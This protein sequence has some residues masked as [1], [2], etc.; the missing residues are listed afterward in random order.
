PHGSVAGLVEWAVSLGVE[1]FGR[2]L[3]STSLNFDV[4]VFELFGTLASGGTLEVVRDV[5][6]LAERESWS[7]SLVSAVPS[8]FAAVL[9][10]DAHV[11]AGLV[12]LAGEAFPSGL[13][14]RIGQVMP[15]AGV[16]NL[17]GP[18]EATVYATG[19]FSGQDAQVDGPMVPIGRSVAG[20]GV[21]V[22]DAWLRPVPVGVWGEL[23]LAGGLARGYH[24]RAGLTSERFVAD[25]FHS[26]GRLYRTGDVV[27]RGAD[28]VLE[29]AG[30]GDDQVKVRGFRIELG[31]IESVLCG[32]GSVSRAVVVAREDRPGVKRLAAY[33]VTDGPDAD[34]D[35]GAVR[36]HVA[37]ALPEYMVPSAF[38]VLEELPLNANGKLDRK[39]LPAPEFTAD[40]GV[41]VAPRTDTER[42][43]ASVWG[44]VLG[45]ADVGVHDNFFDL[46]GDSI[47]SLQVVSRARRAGLAVSSR[48][49][50]Q[51]PTIAALATHARPVAED[52]GTRTR[53]VEAGTVSGTVA[54]T[55]VREW[56]FETHPVAPGHF[57]MAAS[58]ALPDG[59]DPDALRTAVAALTT[60]HDALRS[61]FAR[62]DDGT[63]TG[64]LTAGTDPDA[65][66]TLHELPD[67]DAGDN[68][69]DVVVRDAQAGLDLAAGPL[70][71][72]LVRTG[73]DGPVRVV[74][75]A[76]HLVMDGVSWRILLEDLATAYEQ[77]RAG[78]TP[79]LGPKGTSV[80][81][82]ADR[83]TA[84][85]REGG[86]DDQLDHWREAAAA[87]VRIPV[88]HP[89]GDNTVASERTVSVSL[90]AQETRALLF[91]VPGAYRTRP[92]DV[93]LAAL[94]RAVGP[95]ATG[96]TL[97]VDGHGDGAAG[98]AP[99]WAVNL[100]AHGRGELFDDVDLTRTVGWFTAI[101]PV[102]LPVPAD[103]DWAGTV[104]TVKELLRAVPDQGIGYGAL[105]Y[106]AGAT[107]LGST[108]DLAFN[109]L[110]Q[111]DEGTGGLHRS[112][113]L[114]PGGEHHPAEQRPHLVEVVGAVQDGVLTFTWSYSAN[115][116]DR[117]TVETLARRYADAL[118]SLIAHC[119]APGRP[120][121]CTPSDFPL[122]R[123]AQHEVD[124]LVARVGDARAV[125]DVLPLTPLQSGMLF[126]TLGAPGSPFYLEQFT[127]LME[128]VGD[129]ETVARAWQAV[130]D[131]S[132]A[133]RV[134]VVWEGVAEP[135][136]IVHR[137][138]TRPL[139]IVYADW[140]GRT[141]EERERLLADLLAA[142]RAGAIGLDAPLM[143][144]TL[145]R[146]AD[147]AVRVVW[148]FHHLLMDG[149]SAAAVL[150]DVA[151]LCAGELLPRREPFRDHLSRL[152][153][154]DEA[155]GHAFWSGRLAGFEE[156][157]PLPYDRSPQ[158]AHQACSGE[159]VTLGLAEGAA[160]AV[161]DFARRNRVTVGAVVQG[162]WALL[163]GQYAGRHDVVFGT[164]VSGR[165][166][167]LPGAESTVGLFIN[168]VPVRVV[169]EPDEPVGA[170]LR[171]I[172]DAQ[173]EARA[174]EQVPL[175]GIG[176]PGLPS[177]TPLFDSLVVVENYPVHAVAA[178]RGVTVS[179]LEAVESTNYPLTLTA[180]PA[181][182][183][184]LT[185]GFD[186]E[187]FDA[188]TV[189]LLAARYARVLEALAESGDGA[190]T[191]S[192][193]LLAADERVRVLGGE[194]SGTLDADAV[195]AISLP[196][197][198]ARL[199]AEDPDAV[200]VVGAGG[201]LTRRELD[202]RAER[203]AAAL[204]SRGAGPGARIGLLL[205]RSA[206]VV[207]AM[208][209]VLRTGAAYVPLHSGH[210]ADRMRAMLERSGAL[211]LLTDGVFTAPP[212]VPTLDLAEVLGTGAVPEP[213]VPG[214]A[215][216]AA[217]PVAPDADAYVMYT[218]GSTGEPK[219]VA[220]T[221][222]DIVALA[223]DRRWTRR[224]QQCV[225]F[226]SSHSF[227]AA[228][229]EVW[230]PLLNGGRVVVADGDLTADAVRR[231]VA[232]HG[233]TALFVTTALFGA[234]ADEDPACF[235][236]LGEVWT[237][238][239]AAS[240]PAMRRVREHCS[241]TRLVH[242]YGPTEATAF[243]VC[244]ALDTADLADGAAVPLGLPMDNTLAYVLD[245]ALR[246]VGTGQPGELY[247]GGPGLARGYDGRPG[248]TAERFVADPYGPAG[249]RLYRT[250]DLVRRL[251]DGRLAFLGRGDGQVKIRGFRIELA[252]IE[253]ALGR[254]AGVGRVSVQALAA[255]PDGS[256]KRLVAYLVPAAVQ[257]DAAGTAGDT[258]A[259]TASDPAG[260]DVPRVREQARA[261]LPSY[262]VP[263][264]F[265]VLDALPLNSS[266]KVDRRALPV[267][268]PETTLDH[269]PPRAGT[270]ERIAAVWGELL[271][272]VR[273]GRHD[274]FFALGGDS[275]TSLKAASRLRAALGAD[276][277][278]RTLFDHPT[279]ASLATACAAAADVRT[280]AALAPAPRGADPLPLSYAQERLWFLDAFTPGGNEYN[281]VT[282]LR[283]LG[284]LDT[285][286]LRAAVTAL[287]AR[288]EALR[289]TFGTADGRG[290][291]QR[292]H[293]T[294]AVPV[295][296]LYAADLEEH[297]RAL[298][299]EATAPFDLSTGPLLRVLLVEGPAPDTSTLMLT[300]HHIVT[301]GW[302]MGVVTRELS[303]L[304]AAAADGSAADAELP[305]LPLQ[306]PD[307]AVW[308]RER[309]TDA[310]LA[311]HIDHWRTRL[312][313]LEPLELP[314]DRPRPAVRTG[315]GALH[316]FRVPERLA[317]AL[318]DAARA[319]GAT[320]SMALTAVTQLLLARYS[321]Q[322][323]I[324]VGTAV[325]GRERTELEPL[326]GFFVNTLV[327]RTRVDAR[328]GF[329]ALLA[330]VR[331][332]T[333]AAFEHQAVPFSR[334]VEELAPERDPSRTP[335]VQAAV[336]LQNA[337][338]ETFALPGLVV[339]E[340]LPPVE[341][342]P[343]DLN[344]EFEPTDGDG[345]FAAVTYSTD[346]FDAVTVERMAGHWLGLAEGLVASVA[347]GA[348]LGE[349]PM[350]GVGESALVRESGRG[351]V[352]PFDGAAS[353]VDVFARRAAV[354]PEAVAV[355]CGSAELTYA[356]LDAASD[357]LA[358]VLVERGVVAE[359]RVGLLLERSADVVVAMLGVL[360]AGG[361][362]VPLHASYPEERLRQVLAQAGVCV[363]LTDR[364]VSEVGGVPVLA[365]GS[366]PS[367]VVALPGRV[368]VQS[369]AYVM[370]T[371]GSTGVPKGVAV[372]H[373]DIVAL[374]ADGRWRSGAHD[375]VLFHSPH[376]FDAATYEVWVPLLNGGTVVVAGAELS[377]SVVRDAVAS[378]VSSVFMT[379][380][381][382]DLLAGED[383]GCFAGLRE[384]WTGG[385]AASGAAMGRML[386]HCPDTRLVHVYG[387]T[388]S[389]TF[390]VC[391]PV[392]VGDT[393]A[394]VVPLGA[395]MDN[396][397]A[398]V[399]D[400]SL[401][402]VGVGV[403]GELYLGG[404][405]LVRG[406]DGRA[407]LTAERFVADPFGS[408]ER[409]YRT[410]DLV[411]WRED[412]RLDFLGRGDGQVKI[413][414]FRIEV[415]EVE[416]VLAR[417]T[418]VGR[419]S[420]Q[421]REDRPGVKRLVAYL[422]AADGGDLDMGAVR[423]HAS[424]LLP[425][426]MVP[427]AFVVLDALPLN[428]NG[429][430]DRKAL[431]APETDA[432]EEYVAPRTAAEETLAG[433]WADVLGLE[434]VG[435]HDDFFALGGD[436]IS[437]LQ[438]VSRARRA[439]M[440][441]TSR[442]VFRRPNVADLA[443]SLHASGTAV[444]AVRPAV[445]GP[446][447]PTPV[448]D[449]FFAHHPVAP[450]HFAMSM[451]FES[452]GTVDVVALRTAVAALVDRHDGLRSTFH[453]ADDGAWTAVIAPVAE[454]PVDAV[455]TVHTGYGAD[456][457]GESD[458]WHAHVADAQAG[459][460]L[461]SGPLF[462]VLVGD[463][464]PDRPA[465]LALVAH[466]LLVDGV[467]WRILL[468]DL[469]T[470]YAQARSGGPVRLDAR[471][472][473][474]RDWAERLARHTADGGFDDQASYWSAAVAPDCVTLPVDFPDGRDTMAV[475]STVEVT[476]DAGTTAAL[477]TRTPD[478]YRTR[479][480]DVL[481]A[482]LARVLRSWTGRERTTVDYEGHGREE[483]FADVDLTRTVGWF[484]SIH[485]FAPVL[486]E[487]DD[488]GA[489][490]K[491]VK[492]Q[493]RA[494]PD[495]GIGYGALRHLA[496]DP[497]LTGQP[498]PRISFNFHGRFD[499]SA[500]Q[501][502]GLLG[503]MLPAPG[504]DHH[505]D[506]RRAHELDVI[507]V[508]TD[509]R[510][511]FTW[512]YSTERHRRDTVER[513]AQDLAAQVA[514]FVRHC[515][516]PEAGGRTPSDFPL[517]RLDQPAVDAL[518]GSGPQARDIEDVY[519]LTPLQ[520]GMLFHTL[521]D[522][523]VYLDQVSFS[524]E[525]G[526]DPYALAEAWQRVVD[527]TPALRTHLVWEDVPRPLQVVRRR[528]AL[529]VRHAPP[530][531]DAAV[532]AAQ[533]L[534]AGIDLAS[535]PLMRLALLTERPGAVRVVWT[536]H[537]LVLDG[538]STSR[539]LADVFAQYT[540]L[541]RGTQAPVPAAPPFADYVAWLDRQDPRAAE[542][543]WRRV[544]AGFRAPTP[545]PVD[546][547]P[548]PGHRAH[549]AERLRTALA[550]AGTAA[551]ARMARD[552]GLTLNTVV[553]GAWALLLARYAGETDVCFGATVSG[554]PA[555]LPGVEATVGNF[556]NTLPV[557]TDVGG[558]ASVAEWLRGL[559]D[560]QL[561]ARRHEHLALR[562]VRECADELPQGSELFDSLVV[563]ENYP[564]NEE[565][566]AAHGLRVT[567][568]SAVD[569][570]SYPLDLTAYT[571]ADRL[572]LH[573]SYDPALFDHDR[574]AR[575][576][577]QLA[578]L[579][580]DM[581]ER[582]DVRPA[583]LSMLPDEEHARLVAPGGWSGEAVPYEDGACL[584]E[585]IA[586]Q[587]RRTPDAD[588]VLSGD[589]VLSYAALDTRAN[590]LAHELV[591]RGVRPG[592]VVAICLERGT[593]TVVALLAVLKAG[594][595]YVPLDPAHPADRLAHV[596]ND[597]RARTVLS[598]RSLLPLL[599]PGD[600]PVLA[601]DSEPLCRAVE[602]RPATAPVTRIRP[603]DLAYVIYTSGSTGRPKGV[604]IEHR[605][606]SHGAASWNA[607]YG[608]T[609]GRPVRQLNVASMSFDVFVS[610]LVHALCHGGAL[611]V[612]PSDTVTDPVRLLDLVR[613]ADVTHLDT[614]PA[615]ATALADEAARRGEPLPP[616]RVLA[617]GADLW[618]TDDCR[619]LLDRTDTTR[620]TVL[621]TYG[622]TEATVESCLYPVRADTLPDGASVPIG[623]PNPGIR[624]YVLDEALRPAPVGVTGELYLGG[625]SVGRGYLDRPALTSER[626][627]A[628]PYGDRP[629]D[630]L[631]RTGDRAR[632]LPGGDIEF[633]GRADEQTKIRGFRIE[634]GEIEAAL[635]KHPA[636]ARAV[637]V[638]RP[639][640]GGA[641]QLVGYTV[642]HDGGTCDP[643]ALRAHLRTLVPPYM[644]PAAFVALDTLPLNANGKVDRRALPAPDPAA[645]RT[646]TEY[647]APRTPGEE[648]VA[649]IWQEVLGLERVGAEDDFFDLG[650]DSILTL[651]VTARIRNR[652]GVSL[653]V[654][655]V[656]D[657][658]TVAALADA[659]EERI[660]QELEESMQG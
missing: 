472:S 180:R 534:A 421:V 460:D 10:Q 86:F 406:Y 212:A 142:D 621:N 309:L 191:G 35:M 248:L 624:M 448:R 108:P 565:A 226:H 82:W 12:V 106:L 201:M 177:G 597:S 219:G 453:R 247:L 65:V 34:V 304:Y 659:V 280:D 152:A 479:T 56:F 206:D 211:L 355:R 637:V 132:D 586:A 45:L 371:S 175:H 454:V 449:W 430:V 657:A 75:V 523:G 615:L 141:A 425:E 440:S 78:R 458:T 313:G 535:G 128:G 654:R 188:G 268:G 160:R 533:E 245:A 263:S 136:Q 626:F 456:E 302:S 80:R 271:G 327:L 254:C 265:V 487:G 604:Q 558:S 389:T 383:P 485:P 176:T 192:L 253:A 24:G 185:F 228:T 112:L 244:G 656:H 433:I 351:A 30:R 319:Q 370:F 461:A 613:S 122:V 257:Q 650:G 242:V 64:R 306:Y 92:N 292:V 71:R 509:G 512:T 645:V 91:D 178:D 270:E 407:D 653:T 618:R 480:E 218:S 376:S 549:A 298:R 184:L 589:E 543:H 538:W 4:S 418:S 124:A 363:V 96:G 11:D 548:A 281:V 204:R 397:C 587:A 208:L 595:A 412:G 151:A 333:L 424:A 560:E 256:A 323:D 332:T 76:H 463:R 378:G 359:S 250:G 399:L 447:G 207:V 94:T 396:T 567:D 168:T 441:L 41:R 260:I 58:F 117:E 465:L 658:P 18:T 338:R 607:A 435:V 473:S 158:A 649:A 284:A 95:W 33:L 532:L 300:M 462:R 27:R 155:V 386:E 570:T 276:L 236:G 46:G 166:E 519:P 561:E 312:A 145:V 393:R 379:K 172:G 499:T 68:A 503:R 572:A 342:S 126:H 642:A 478:V 278:P 437:S 146:V 227:D 307:F 381:L 484:T 655:A 20:K 553:Q 232:E 157:T 643:D 367:G 346:L 55:P 599:P 77:A 568:V 262:M 102:A 500:A 466:H 279:V 413:R 445:T 148:S 513:L 537:H 593:R 524:L 647:V 580:R 285:D 15:G 193:P 2:V 506:E 213:G 109:Y 165:P 89:G 223:A 420:V 121:G 159:R 120:A 415:A 275:I 468:E 73:T 241:D 651:Q 182:E 200:A 442:D 385:E 259:V 488:H 409:L 103:D 609:D 431:P 540:A 518:V 574:V 138:G 224:T 274:D 240:R 282:T 638:A 331:E 502:G 296:T 660:L 107:D 387:P 365:V 391:G 405:G 243:A 98:P 231:A 492:E 297:H 545:L 349:V 562:T 84:Y 261:L 573:L 169:T 199:V 610:D 8:A 315:R 356:E 475:Q 419:V 498:A 452:A 179:G 325:S 364:D 491:A 88:D 264:A 489:A 170:W 354:A 301:D 358:G 542:A 114:N 622:V 429:K 31:E 392:G 603:R 348:V 544:L 414:G 510:L 514:D 459:M 605:S 474:V 125:E 174:H 251:P 50:F 337:P 335:L 7:G 395:V 555:D 173:A 547:T 344:M 197:Q 326:V 238:G 439:G 416:A 345:L 295:R 382:F 403:V 434:Q 181:G 541:T 5:L 143:R 105:R 217:G 286:A 352:A 569:T 57:N 186:P 54:T 305:E 291:T 23:Y 113:V 368:P 93:L 526:D 552:H 594:A 581:A 293:A 388:E 357:R 299:A 334:L 398:Y 59:M 164:T 575:L 230:A 423:A 471:T 51:H 221:H 374:V 53:L 588:A 559:Q 428:A 496:A 287:V 633:A 557:R 39:A 590:R 66:L 115:V 311:P 616:L 290:G 504:G 288:H 508:I 375:V 294:T 32:H 634:P 606:V 133:L 52:A 225:L 361:V 410:G 324:A 400:G 353:V 490:V 81:Q 469:E 554:R 630:R 444:D 47:I 258:A 62:E 130:V 147:D 101:H 61:T 249:G 464:G 131:A 267:P 110:G 602:R 100:E 600:A 427:S 401:R 40:Q 17:Y 322:D 266:G 505:P 483:L 137:A 482:G 70:V 119:A 44:E 3:F 321:G 118:R 627:V 202:A 501:D 438:V 222:R 408:G 550:P 189:R 536:F 329:G 652:F 29:Y 203:L 183:F 36:E 283:L 347:S 369:L 161:A 563:F 592:D 123:L 38:V 517:A 215:P 220:V 628:D 566:A 277:S 149:W 22:L 233:V 422:V 625:P 639:D 531:T 360:K 495:R 229:Y 481:L 198:Y 507:G 214:V 153:G 477:L 564:G 135:V 134:S 190:T 85:V 470:A 380:A 167:D 521:A 67:G 187:L 350:W 140:T 623:R 402:P 127:F 195:P 318:T 362:Y 42:V 154:R 598:Q 494:V 612:A 620:T 43:L 404:S 372:T 571:D 272:T 340:A 320:L 49:V 116:H 377:A 601:L 171:R 585:L 511:T 591:E 19:W 314:T 111:F 336:T 432:A 493:L 13:R 150:S 269:E 129:V 339:E 255:G 394:S 303:A 330:D 576:A 90:T 632:H 1:R 235:A 520:S 79:D 584:H 104:S 48:D 614:V 530:G 631:Y 528:A 450:H 289:T 457:A 156:R 234:L 551:V 69:W 641:P 83:L 635:R 16:A 619:R 583:A 162:A 529:S 316:S 97:P 646:G 640:H 516:A 87:A 366:A 237:G 611:V 196:E 596:L 144:L 373:G 648:L 74:V 644:V 310:A 72:V 629:G 317:T 436:S 6:V 246:P 216:A 252:E 617:V 328:A 522:P 579:L 63:W 341:A 608:F 486:P 239:E 636:V 194:W 14:E 577:A 210:P 497:R 417:H 26:G 209:A 556:L 525:G 21:Y 139:P 273:I 455:L 28:G 25:P 384:V 343:F 578:H 515:T 308:Q 426:Y 99:R 163:L 546:R 411:R 476:L 451:A 60:Q 582:P 9:E 446:V 539:I 443:A 527:A 37:A 467:S 205:D 390:A